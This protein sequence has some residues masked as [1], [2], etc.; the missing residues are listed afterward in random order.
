MRAPGRVSLGVQIAAQYVTCY[1]GFFACVIIVLVS[2][3]VVAQ[4]AC[5]TLF[6]FL[7]SLARL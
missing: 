5:D 4:Y 1:G 6:N 2:C 3:R 7:H